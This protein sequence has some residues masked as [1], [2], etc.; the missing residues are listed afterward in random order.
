VLVLFLACFVQ[1]LAV[2]HF[3]FVNQASQFAN[4]SHSKLL[5]SLGRVQKVLRRVAHVV[6][7]AG[8]PEDT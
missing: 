8:K 6:S 7:D 3:R 2:A 5:F 4:A 1:A